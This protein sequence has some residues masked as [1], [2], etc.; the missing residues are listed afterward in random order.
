MANVQIKSEKLTPFGRIFPIMEQ[1]DALLAQTID[2]TISTI[3]ANLT[4]H[5]LTLYYLLLFSQDSPQ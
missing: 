1:F 3:H 4:R 2:S 5:S